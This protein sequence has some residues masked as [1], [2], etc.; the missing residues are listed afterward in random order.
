MRLPCPRPAPDLAK[1]DPLDFHKNG[2]A[3]A[4]VGAALAHTGRFWEFYS[5]MITNGPRFG[6]A[7]I[8]TFARAQ[9]LS[10]DALQAAVQDRD[11]LV[12]ARLTADQ[13]LAIMHGISGTPTF[14]VNGK[15]LDGAIDELAFRFTIVEELE[16]AQKVLAQGVPADQLYNTLTGID[17]HQVSATQTSP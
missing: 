4:R 13:E 7:E 9:G 6:Q 17:H 8:E 3:A 15:R 1:A 10:S 16:R 11:P 14:F 12:R 5:K 2:Q